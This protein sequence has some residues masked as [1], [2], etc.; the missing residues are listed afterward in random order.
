MRRKVFYVVVS[1]LL[2][3]FICIFA[4]LQFKKSQDESNRIFEKNLSIIADGLQNLGPRMV[5]EDARIDKSSVGP[6]RQINCEI[7][8]LKFTSLVDKLPKDVI[9]NLNSDLRQS[10]IKQVHKLKDYDYMRKNN[11]QFVWIY[12]TVN[13][14]YITDVTLRPEDY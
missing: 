3:S 11:V 9:Q 14:E 4:F 13:N 12:K 6:G 7:T 5:N 8:L 1:L 10:L 2:L